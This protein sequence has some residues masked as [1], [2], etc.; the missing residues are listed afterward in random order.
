ML[1]IAHRWHALYPHAVNSSALMGALT[2]EQPTITLWVRRGEELEECTVLD[3]LTMREVDE[4]VEHLPCFST[5]FALAATPQLQHLHLQIGTV[6]PARPITDMFT[7]VPR[8]RSLHIDATNTNWSIKRPTPNSIVCIRDMLAALS[9]LAQL[10]C[11]NLLLDMQDLIDIA[12]HA[13]LEDIALNPLSDDIHAQ[14]ALGHSIDFNSDDSTDDDTNQAADS[15]TTDDVE[16]NHAAVNGSS[17][18]AEQ[19]KRDMERL[20]IALTR[21]PPSYRSV[22]ARLSLA[23]F[24]RRQLLRSRST[25][26]Q[27]RNV[28]QYFQLFRIVRNNDHRALD[29]TRQLL[30]QVTTLRDTLSTQLSSFIL[31]SHEVD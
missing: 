14:Y 12:A 13:T 1:D 29:T 28:P 19:H 15:S 27:R 18:E 21:V 9:S 2:A 3:L 8:L 30:R 22:R 24:I 11:T 31:V 10:H 5:D 6:L 26:E 16:M 4:I 7:L 25:I 23:N 20:P 17:K